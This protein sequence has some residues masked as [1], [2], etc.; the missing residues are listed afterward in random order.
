MLITINNFQYKAKPDQTILEVAQEKG[1]KIPTLCHDPN[2][3]N[4]GACRMCI[5]EIDESKR[6]G[7]NKLVAACTTP[8]IEGMK[9]FT[10][11][12]KVI[13]SRKTIL[14]LLLADHPLD[15]L[16]CEANG[17]CSLQDL[18][19]EYGVTESSYGSKT[20]S[21]FEIQNENPFIEVDPDKCILCGKCIRV[22][23]EIQSSYAI[24]FVNRGFQSK[25]ATPFDKGLGGDYSSCVFCGQCV[26][27][28]PTAALTYKPSKRRGRAYD[29]KKVQT[30]CPYCGVGCQLELRI[31]DNKVIQV[32]SVYKKD[33]PNPMGE[34]CVK[35]RFG[36]DY[37]NHA[38]RLT[39]PLI[40]RDG[41]FKEV[42]W[43][44]ALD[45]VANKLSEIKIKCG[46]D[47]IAGLS[48]AKCTNEENYL[49][50]KFMRAVIGTNNIDH[51]ARLCHAST[52]VG[53]EK[54]FGSGAMTNSIEEVERSDVIFVIGS[55]PTENHPVIGSKIKRAIKKGAKLIVADPRE[56]E[57][58]SYANV[59]LAQ[60]P[61]TDVALI[62]GLMHVI[63]KENLHDKEFIEKRTINFEIIESIVAE[64]T[65]EKVEKITKVLAEDIIK[66][67]RLFASNDRG[68]I[69]YAM[70]ITQHKTG[71]DNVLALANLALLT[72]N[73]GRESTGVNPLRGQNNVQGACDLAALPNVYPGYQVVNNSANC[74]K[75]EKIWQAKLS[76]K[77]GLT[78]QEM[79]NKSG[80]D[81][82]AMYIM[83]EN[84]VISDPDQNHVIKALESLDFLIVQ[85]IF[86]TETAEFADV[87][88]PASSFAEKDGTFTNTERRVQLVNKAIESPGLARAD[89][90]IIADLSKR[91]GYEMK[92]NS[93]EE[94][95]KEIAKVTPIYGGIYHDRLKE[96][97]LQWPC[98]DRKHQGT[99]FLHAGQFAT[100]AHGGKGKF[101]SVTYIPPAEEPDEEYQY[102]LMTGRMLYHFHT[103]TMTRRS[104]AIN[105][106]ES[107]AYVEINKKDAAKLKIRDGDRVR[108]ISRRGEVETFARVCYRVQTGQ[109]FMPFHYAE[110]P[111]NC[112][113]NPVLDPEA[114]IPELKVSAVKVEKV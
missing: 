88:L 12:D 105:E 29:F 89:W 48:S 9:I 91:M 90:E 95:M 78:I 32:G 42:S 99:K 81:I 2:L 47:S 15:C 85:D 76:E 84:P 37:I 83:G 56:I 63:I 98:L 14:E 94:I 55:N 41:S 18:A 27:I 38:D 28:C 24:E 40:K 86:L 77:V 33:S 112:L 75:F 97:S 3:S 10:D 19:Y 8:V 22:D 60:R 109:L 13:R 36:Y 72:G 69:Y 45:F 25:V 68:A 102:I 61:G 7:E 96:K 26:E 65:P 104:K 1:I 39:T 30:T 21:R 93:A 54:A 20:K 11:S 5:V 43:D 34:S 87:I 59:N 64:Y 114:K 62:N 49:M 71:T 79:L 100:H 52:V 67:A 46:S 111:A 4:V 73:V 92:Y 51:C 35:G 103:G 70:G 58:S 44:E 110:S 106:Y 80:E 6:S 16:T 107:D 23:Q 108:V 101:F 74:A 17:N 31:K 53:L 66:A 57:L 50:Q 82:K 113:T